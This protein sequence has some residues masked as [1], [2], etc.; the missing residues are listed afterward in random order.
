MKPKLQSK[1]ILLTGASS[2]MGKSIATRL[3]KQ[4]HI[5]YAVARRVEKMN[6]LVSLGGRVVE[7]D[8]TNDLQCSRTVTQ[9]L[10]ECGRIDVLIN[11]AGYSVYG[12]VEDVS[13][14]DA[15]RQFEVNLFGL[16][17]LTQKVLPSMREDQSGHI[18]NVTSVGGKIYAPL[19]AWYHASKH[20]V[21]GWSDCLRVEVEQFGIKVSI[22][23]PGAI[24]TEFYDVMN[25]AMLE[26]SKGGSYESLVAAN[27][28]AAKRI[29]DGSKSTNPEVVAAV[30][31]RV[32][33]ARKP[34]TRYPVGK[35]ARA[36]LF[37]RRWLSDS[38][39]D[40]MLRITVR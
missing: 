31:E 27:I 15:R 25:E 7:M 38:L 8:V 22:V 33:Q 12:A 20:A 29:H 18:I 5:V 23:E 32:I 35:L 9:I 2:G 14:A 6:D 21:E 24:T 26:R 34:R 3:I 19:G 17:F 13:Q 40:Q 10:D 11:N 4:G 39:F 36:S 37:M 1:V 28:S 16:A 30:V